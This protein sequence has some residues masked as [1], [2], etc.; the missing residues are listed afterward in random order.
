MTLP[1]AAVVIGLHWLHVLFGAF[2]FGSQMYLDVT[3]RPATARLEPAA[4]QQLG[5]SMGRGLARQI[6]VFVATGTV[7]TGILR[8]IAVGVLGRLDTPYG[9]TWLAALAITTFMMVSVWTRG[10][11]GRVRAGVLWTGLF[12]V[13][14]SLMIAMRFGL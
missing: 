10:F 14:F 2:W 12:V 8:G 11:G 3:V 4:Q 9:L 5:R 6:T 13:V 1:E 7:V